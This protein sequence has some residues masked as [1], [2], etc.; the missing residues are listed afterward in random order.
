MDLSTA[1]EVKLS[2]LH[3]NSFEVSMDFL[4]EDFR[5]S[6][7]LDSTAKTFVLNEKNLKIVLLDGSKTV[8]RGLHDLPNLRII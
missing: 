7:N 5:L 3:F 6:I 4:F 2:F 1:L 8:V